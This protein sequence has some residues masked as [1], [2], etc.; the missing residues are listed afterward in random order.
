MYLLFHCFKFT[1]SGNLNVSASMLLKTDVFS[2]VLSAKYVFIFFL[3][4]R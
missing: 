2:Y 3:A 4:F 1:M